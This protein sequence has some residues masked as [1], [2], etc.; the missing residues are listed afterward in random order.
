[1][2]VEAHWSSNLHLGGLGTYVGL[3][4]S[5][6]FAAL[7]YWAYNAFLLGRPKENRVYYD[8]RKIT[9]KIH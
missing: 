9:S 7:A 2:A 8:S 6:H 3:V 5:L 4:V 1:M